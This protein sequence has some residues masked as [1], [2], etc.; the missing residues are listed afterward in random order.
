MRIRKD[1]DQ[2]YEEQVR[3]DPSVAKS[4]AALLAGKVPRRKLSLLCDECLEGDFVE[5]LKNE[6]EYFRVFTLPKGRSDEHLWQEA[7]QKKR[8]IVTS[9]RDFLDDHRYPLHQSPGVLY[10]DAPSFDET[11]M[12]FARFF[13][14]GSFLDLF[15]R[16]GWSVFEGTKSSVA[17][18]RGRYRSHNGA[19]GSILIS[20]L[21]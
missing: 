3:L 5:W 13:V 8:L 7:R 10:L 12:S 14:A 11:I 2:W 16:V 1:M 17:P 19:D 20:T 4:T 15:N 18:G 6:P 21:W 9:D